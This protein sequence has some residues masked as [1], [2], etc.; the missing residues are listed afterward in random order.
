MGGDGDRTAEFEIDGLPENWRPPKRSFGGSR[1]EGWT[2]SGKRMRILGPG[3]VGTTLSDSQRQAAEEEFR[4][5]LGNESKKSV[6]DRAYI[7]RLERPVLFV[8]PIQ[9]NTTQ[10][11]GSGTKLPKTPMIAIAVIVPGER[12]DQDR[13]NLTYMFNAPA[14]R[15]WNPD[16][17]DDLGDDDVE[18]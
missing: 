18:Q 16:F 3:D 2:V 7:K 8:Y 5:I 9:P 6:P 1:D 15:L 13:D 11:A 14:Q 10:G 12:S 17:V 4:Q